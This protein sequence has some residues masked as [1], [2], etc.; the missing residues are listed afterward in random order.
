MGRS[1]RRLTGAAIGWSDDRP[2]GIVTLTDIADALYEVRAEAADLAARL[3]AFR[4]GPA[5][6]PHGRRSDALP[7]ISQNRE[8]TVSERITDQS[9]LKTIR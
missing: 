8:N 5:T 3:G 2:A 9:T 4:T 7:L 1:A 6:S